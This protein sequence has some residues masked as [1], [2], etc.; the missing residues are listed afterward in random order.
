L[1]PLGTLSGNGPAETF[2]VPA[3]LMLLSFSKWYPYTRAMA[4]GKTGTAASASAKS[5]VLK[6]R[7]LE[8]G[9]SPRSAP[10]SEQQ[11]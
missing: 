5:G 3:T 10:C 6:C 1:H 4:R 8:V 11:E 7:S 2:P 9:R